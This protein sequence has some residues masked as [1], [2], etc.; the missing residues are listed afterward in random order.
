MLRYKD[1]IAPRSIPAANLPKGPHARYFKNSYFERDA[2]RLA[3]P[4]RIIFQNPELAP[5]GA[6][7]PGTVPIAQLAGRCTLFHSSELTHCYHLP[8]FIFVA[9]KP[10]RSPAPPQWCRAPSTAGTDTRLSFTVRFKVF[11]VR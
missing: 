1:L 9:V 5:P 7:L 8:L 10:R 11:S 3:T 6:Q 4:P 2:R